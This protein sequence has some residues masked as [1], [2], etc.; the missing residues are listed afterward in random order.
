MPENTRWKDGQSDELSVASGVATDVL[1][2]GEFRGVELV[3]TNHSIK[4]VSGVVDGQKVE[5][6]AFGFDLAGIEGVHAVVQ[7]AGKGHVKRCHS[8]DFQSTYRTSLQC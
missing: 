8:C 7:P 6:D 3:P 4:D 5:V 2:R 1:R